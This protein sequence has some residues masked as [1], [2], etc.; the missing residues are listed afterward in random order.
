MNGYLVRPGD[1]GA[2]A[3]RILDVLR[4]EDGG[5]SM[6]MRGR[7]RVRDQFSFEA[8]G[9]QYQRFFEHLLARAGWCAP[10]RSFKK[11]G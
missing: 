6:G 7:K 11:A 1:L 10:G 2:L 3:A 9:E 5:K 8:Q 4:T